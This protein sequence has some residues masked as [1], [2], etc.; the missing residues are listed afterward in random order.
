V[1]AVVLIGALFVVTV[2]LWFSMR[3][4][5]GRINVDLPEEAAPGTGGERSAGGAAPEPPSAS[6]QGP[7]G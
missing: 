3:K 7:R 5:L 6:D 4:H 2:L 1:L